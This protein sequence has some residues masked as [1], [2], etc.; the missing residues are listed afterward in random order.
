MRLLGI[1][2]LAASLALPSRAEAQEPFVPLFDGKSLDGWRV[3]ESPESFSVVGGELVVKGPRAHL[4]YVG[5]VAQAQFRNFELEV[6]AQTKKGANSGVFFHTRFQ[7]DGWPAAGYETQVNSTHGDEIKSGSLYGV[8]KVNPAPTVDDQWFTMNVRVV[9]RRVTVKIDG[10]T[11]V[12]WLEPSDVSG[13]RRLSRGT[14]AL[15]AHDPESEVHYRAVRVRTLP[16]GDG[17]PL[18]RA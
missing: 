10:K 3:N 17:P 11:V 7:P 14:F 1:L 18:T 4:F 5:S 6:E 15:Q 9:G 2:G 16:D 13:E 8:V 12:D